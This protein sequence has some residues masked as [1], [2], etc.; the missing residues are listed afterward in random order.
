MKDDAVKSCLHFGQWVTLAF[1][2]VLG[3][4]LAHDAWRR[5]QP[6]DLALQRLDQ[7]K[8]GNL[9]APALQQ[10]V[11]ELDYVYRATYFQTQDRQAYG[12]LLLGSAFL[13]LCLLTGMEHFFC[14]PRL[15]TPE[16]HAA[17][18]EDER[19]QLLLLVLLASL[20]LTAAILILQHRTAAQNADTAADT[21]ALDGAPDPASAPAPA[22]VPAAAPIDIQ[23]ALLA[24]TEHWPQFRGSLLPNRNPLPARWQ[25]QRKWQQRIPLEGYS[26]PVIWDDRIFVS[27][28]NKSERVLFCYAA[29]SGELLWRLASSAAPL[30]PE[31]TADTGYAAPTPCLDRERVYAVFA[32]GEVLCCTHTGELLWQRQLPPP[33]ILYGYASSPLLLGDRLILQYDLEETQT[34]YALDVHSGKSLWETR[35]ESTPSWSSP[36]AFCQDDKITIFTA[37][38]KFAEAFA[39]D[40]GQALWRFDGL[41]GEVA[42]SA[43]AGD[44][45]FFFS[46]TGAITASFAA[47]DGQIGFRND[48][49]PAPDVASPLLLGEVFLLFDSGG[50]AI[51]LDRRTGEELFEAS[52]SDGFYASPVAVG[53]KI[54][55][56]NLSGELL[57]LSA[58][59]EGIITE[60]K[61]DLGN[62]VVAVPAFH[63]GNL[64]MRTFD[65]DLLYLETQNQ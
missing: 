28:G 34:L 43:V 4:L 50:L 57:L 26:S 24:G 30:V 6:L 40:T 5:T 8:A 3:A 2:L 19:Q 20:V 44:G 47:A 35:R 48:N 9:E 12:F 14:R 10:T 27:G 38:N 7:L 61:Y 55:A 32:T 31:V 62:K 15:H 51:G 11:R 13:L 16:A 18:A 42:T 64:V 25:F 54:V 59:R 41:G 60:G 33:Q 65:N 29:E 49:T 46:N 53:G 52:F 37:G 36:S 22:P 1:L 63:R 45:Q 58:S 17:S 23:A 21:A 39:A 56:V